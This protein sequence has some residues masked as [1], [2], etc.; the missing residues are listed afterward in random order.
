M[1]RFYV[2]LALNELKVFTRTFAKCALMNQVHLLLNKGNGNEN[3]SLERISRTG[4]SQFLYCHR[5]PFFP[6]SE[7]LPP[8]D[9]CLP[10]RTYYN[11]VFKKPKPEAAWLLDI[12]SD[13][14]VKSHFRSIPDK[15]VVRNATIFFL[16]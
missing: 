11:S 10:R 1:C 3:N 4:E 8:N 5:I 13:D 2:L 14:E 9:V 7:V 16:C 15:E 6:N 12:D